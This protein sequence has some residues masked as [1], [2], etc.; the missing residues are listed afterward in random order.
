[1]ISGMETI[2]QFTPRSSGIP[3]HTIKSTPGAPTWDEILNGK[4]NV[5]AQ[6]V[7][8]DHKPATVRTYA[9][10]EAQARGGEAIVQTL[11]LGRRIEVC[12][13]PGDSEIA[14]GIRAER[15]RR[16][17]ALEA[18]RAAAAAAAASAT[19]EPAVTTPAA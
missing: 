3:A 18:K 2:E 13:Y 15:E 5:L 8:F 4:V 7:D 19:P 14:K 11:N 6:G 16:T 9:L 10:A 12:F 1:M 17:A